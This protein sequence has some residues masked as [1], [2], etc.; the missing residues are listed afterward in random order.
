MAAE[1]GQGVAAVVG[2]G[3]GLGAAL[4]RRFA[5]GYRVA[6]VAR[7]AEVI[8]KVSNDITANGGV[9]VAIRGDATLESQVA[10]SHERI[11]NELGPIDVLIYNGGRRPMGRLLETTPDVFER[12]EEHTSEL[13]S[14]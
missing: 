10:A 4:A 3:E 2:V 11:R 9:A 12:S 14:L 7:S 8:E 5:T 13:Q 6:L 1:G